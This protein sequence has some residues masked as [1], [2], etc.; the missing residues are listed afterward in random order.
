MKLVR[1]VGPGFVA[2]FVSD[3]SKVVRA[4]PYL[5]KLV[6]KSE[7]YARET[8]ARYGWKAS[9]VKED[10]LHHPERGQQQDD[11]DQGVVE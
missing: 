4:A 2:G 6:G 9:V 8:I 7:T 3:G 11:L 5:K 10:L 1:V